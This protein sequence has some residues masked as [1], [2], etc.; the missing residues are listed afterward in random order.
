MGGDPVVRSTGRQ[1]QSEADPPPPDDLTAEI[2]ENLL[3]DRE[4]IV[5]GFQ[6][7]SI[8]GLEVATLDGPLRVRTMENPDSRRRRNRRRR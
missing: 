2:V 3:D 6:R 4:I 7:V 1:P 8:L 5:D